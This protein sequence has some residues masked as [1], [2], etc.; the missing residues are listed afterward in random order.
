MIRDFYT[1]HIM[2]HSLKGLLPKIKSD[3]LLLAGEKDPY[4]PGSHYKILMNDLINAQT[5]TGHLFT[6]AEGGAEHCQRGNH[7]LAIKCI[8]NWLSVSRQND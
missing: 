7:R 1:P 6:E 5:V 2:N 8:F 3:V 4:I